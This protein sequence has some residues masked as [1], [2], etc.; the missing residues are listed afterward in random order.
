MASS[1]SDDEGGSAQAKGKM[2]DW[3]KI[4]RARE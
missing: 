4:E 3:G 1:V 2:E